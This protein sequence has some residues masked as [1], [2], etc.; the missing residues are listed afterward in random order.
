MG[1]RVLALSLIILFIAS[2]KNIGSAATWPNNA[3]TYPQGISSDYGWR[4]YDNKFHKGL[5]FAGDLVVK[6]VEGG[7]VTDTT[8]PKIIS[9]GED[10]N[11]GRLGSGK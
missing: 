9:G 4:T 10:A 8:L 7:R 2:L 3:Y 5:D 1:K 6:G 11:D